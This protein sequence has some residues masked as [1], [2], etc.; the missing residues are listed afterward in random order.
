MS[1]TQ[2]NVFCLVKIIAAAAAVAESR[3]SKKV[4]IFSKCN[5][6]HLKIF[7]KSSKPISVLEFPYTFRIFKKN[8]KF[9]VKKGLKMGTKS[10]R[11]YF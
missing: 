7:K 2:K 10:K 8:P 5:F 9:L 6:K 1:G 4:N 11:I 3:R